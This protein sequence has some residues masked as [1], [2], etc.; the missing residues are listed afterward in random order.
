M[1]K[2]VNLR[3]GALLF[4]FTLSELL[5][6]VLVIS[7]ILVA[8]APVITKRTSD[9]ISINK[10]Q[11]ESI[12]ITFSSS[13]EGCKLFTL[14]SGLENL[15][16][17]TTT[18]TFALGEGINNINAIIQSAGG[19]GSNADEPVLEHKIEVVSEDKVLEFSSD[20]VQ[21]LK[22]TYMQGAGGGGG[23]AYAE[24]LS[25]EPVDQSDCDPY[26]A[27]FINKTK[28]GL[29]ESYC[30]QRYNAGDTGGIELPDS[31][32]HKGFSGGL[33][34]PKQEYLN[35]NCCWGGNFQ[36][37]VGYTESASYSSYSGKNRKVCQYNAAVKICE[38]YKPD[39]STWV[40]PKTELV[41]LFGMVGNTPQPLNTI[42]YGQL[43][44]CNGLFNNKDSML[45]SSTIYCASKHNT[46]I[47]YF[48]W[49]DVAQT[50]EE[51]DNVEYN[52]VSSVQK[53]CY[54]AFVWLQEQNFF[55]MSSGYTC[56]ATTNMIMCGEYSTN[57]NDYKSQTGREPM[58]VR[59]VSS[60]LGDRYKVNTGGGGASAPIFVPNPD[61]FAFQTKN[62]KLNIHIGSG[63]A[64][65][66]NSSQTPSYGGDTTI[67]ITH[68]KENGV[69]SSGKNL[70]ARGAKGASNATSTQA[71]T[72][73]VIFT[74]A[75]AKPCQINGS[76]TDC[77]DYA[78]KGGN[79]AAVSNILVKGDEAVGGSGGG[80]KY[81]VN[82]TLNKLEML[83]DYTTG[84]LGGSLNSPNGANGQIYGEGGAG[85]SATIED[86]GTITYGKGGDGADGVVVIEYDEIVNNPKAGA[87]GSGGNL[88]KVLNIPYTVG[89]NLRAALQRNTPDDDANRTRFF[90]PTTGQP[91]TCPSDYNK[92]D[93]KVKNGKNA[94]S[95]QFYMPNGIT[96]KDAY[97][98][99]PAEGILES[100][101]DSVFTI[102]GDNVGAIEQR[103][104]GEAGTLGKFYYTDSDNYASVD[105]EDI[106]QYGGGNDILLYLV[107]GRGGNSAGG[108]MGGCGGLVPN[109]MLCSSVSRSFPDGQV[110]AFLAPT[111]PL[112]FDYGSAGAGGGG[113][114]WTREPENY[115]GLST[116][117]GAQ[118]QDGY[119]Y[120]WWTKV[121]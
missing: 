15:P 34:C 118:G 80:T 9:N 51:K 4:G 97:F 1:K 20:R 8:M 106:F 58:S 26:N 24:K 115:G 41:S 95:A 47:A 25:G 66:N 76:N 63:G 92:F 64:G 109:R 55:G 13:N 114:G 70:L 65:S 42:A 21:N 68:C 77:K 37:S 78:Q 56:P 94:P 28:S 73:G 75:S 96:Q 7:I 72:G 40:L 93:F 112:A 104:L 2:L 48:C 46:N 105:L 53:I 18:C 12:L 32:A 120:I 35:A 86:D 27:Y 81:N 59:C 6:S 54:P 61:E 79:G 19:W 29:N 11:T 22:V 14:D 3:M 89:C 71:G 67:G 69:C 117:V 10:V 88:L 90:T 74:D 49:L 57:R 50:E 33:R 87:G 45:Y 111:N 39:N 116:G 91:A 36:T 30:F 83:Q 102:T 84:T 38:S 23:F 85:A 60:N 121:E 113:G 62:I 31:V 119:I 43:F 17:D 44:L 82:S 103:A 101:L 99:E 16:S 107:G 52:P 100:D 5:M 98:K 108:T 110:G